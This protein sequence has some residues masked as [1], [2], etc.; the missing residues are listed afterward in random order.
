MKDAKARLWLGFLGLG[1]LIGLVTVYKVFTEGFVLYA[2]TNVLIW[3]LP[4]AAYIFFSLTSSGLAFVSSIPVVFGFKKYEPLE[5]R[6]VFLEIAV[7][8]AGFICLVMHLGSP[9]NAVYFL[10]SPNPASPLWWLGVFYGI[11]LVVLLASFWKMHTAKV[12]HALSTLVFLIAI[13]TS[14]MLG[15]LFGLPDGRPVFSGAFLTMYFPL[16]A[17]ACGLAAILLFSLAS[18]KLPLYTALFL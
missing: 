1:V 17:F 5:K 6:I 11:Y 15:W 12:S 3:T 14:T 4:L 9:L 7:L 10:L 13:G 2:K 8:I 18:N 16:T